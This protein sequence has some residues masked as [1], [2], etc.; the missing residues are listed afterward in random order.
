MNNKLVKSTLIILVLVLCASCIGGAFALYSVNAEPLVVQIS[1]VVPDSERISIRGSWDGWTADRELTLSSG[2]Y[3]W[4]GNMTGGTEFKGYS[5]TN[6]DFFTGS[7]YAIVKDGNYT[8][9]YP[10][11][12]SRSMADVTV[13]ANSY[14]YTFYVHND[15]RSWVYA[16]GDIL[17]ANLWTEG[18]SNNTWVEMTQDSTDIYKWTFDAAPAFDRCIIVRATSGTT[19]S[20]AGW[21]R[22]HNQT[23]N[24][25]ISGTSIIS[26][27][28]LQ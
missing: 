23:D 8:V 4:T 25:D 5:I 15:N 26:N 12:G 16:D 13:T 19:A 2:T 22:K 11:Q 10:A 1:A 21:D 28:T 3:S 9:S 7:N 6:N 17:I 14:T 18:Q 20:N 27:Y 24:V